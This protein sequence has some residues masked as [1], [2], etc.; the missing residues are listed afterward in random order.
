MVSVRLVSLEVLR[1]LLDDRDGG[2]HVGWLWGEQDGGRVVCS[3][4]IRRAG[5]AEEGE[6]EH[7]LRCADGRRRSSMDPP[8]KS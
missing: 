4:M 8:K 3:G 2:R 5:M 7:Q 1:A 6:A